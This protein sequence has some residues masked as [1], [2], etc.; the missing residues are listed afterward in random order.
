MNSI[1]SRRTAITTLLGLAF[2]V[3]LPAHA[4]P[5]DPLAFPLKSFT[6][7]TKDVK[8]GGITHHIRYRAYRHIPYVA[9]PVSTEFE[10]LDVE[11]PVEIDGKPVDA[12]DAPI[13]MN[14]MVNGYMSVNNAH[15]H[16]QGFPGGHPP[17]GGKPGDTHGGPGMAMNHPDDPAHGNGPHSAMGP[18][19]GPHGPGAGGP[20]GPG[21]PERKGELA[22]AAGYVVV[23]PG[24]RGSDSQDAQGHY[25][26]KAPAAIVDLK[27][28]V[29]YIHHNGGHM[30]GNPAWVVSAGCSAAGGLSAL[31]GASGDNPA[32]APYLLKLGAAEASDKVFASAC[33]SPI[34]DLDHADMSYEWTYGVQKPRMGSVDPALSVQLAT[35]FAAYEDGLGL[36]G[37]GSFGP[38]TTGRLADYMLQEYLEP[39]ATQYLGKMKEADRVHY[40]ADNPWMH[41]K[42]QSASFTFADYIRHTGRFKGLPVFDS[43]DLNSPETG[44]FGTSAKRAQNFTATGLRHA[45]GKPDAEPDSM[46]RERVNL[47][48]PMFFLAHNGSAP[49]R[50]WLFHTGTN[51]GSISPVVLVNL[52]TRLE[53]QGQDVH[54]TLFWDG[55][56]CADYEPAGMVEW[57]SHLT[58]YPAL[59]LDRK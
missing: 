59:A 21:G 31:L 43:F 33:Y 26:G 9:H 10:S 28:V 30:P 40:L 38:L 45:T 16:R 48:N 35:D 23:T 53:N 58:G 54:A 39:A 15:P 13:V 37:R 57:I 1:F 24:V 6:I 44:L 55:G 5:T 12:S 27:A 20:Q 22:L 17:F 41:W 2:A 18:N 14:I 8:F 34:T 47:M 36:K 25:I 11:V 52:A 51:D 46:L 29:R 7:E 19:G 4:T 42:N 56:H 32:Y 3:T 50:H 49:T